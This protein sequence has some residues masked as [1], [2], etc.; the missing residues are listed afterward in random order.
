MRGGYNGW[1]RVP[2]EG[3]T[4]KK[5]SERRIMSEA[6][7]DSQG[8]KPRKSKLAIVSLVLPLVVAVFLLVTYVT[9]VRRYPPSPLPPDIPKCIFLSACLIIGCALGIASLVQIKKS[10]GKLTGSALALSGVVLSGLL[11]S[12]LVYNYWSAYRNQVLRGSSRCLANLHTLGVA[13]ET[14]AAENGNRYPPHDK[15][16]DLLLEPVPYLHRTAPLFVY[17]STGEWCC[18]YA[19]NPN[20]RTD[21]P[22][23]MVLLFETKRGWNQFGGREILTTENH[24]PKGCHVLFNDG[25]VRFVKTSQVGELKWKAEEKK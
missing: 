24:K 11:A 2:V 16:C 10:R 25:S 17:L 15:W 3:R 14:Y 19:M 1:L 7:N 4:I 22:P 20:C 23:D 9:R 5:F 8:Q 13:L 6:E 18:I 12:G 21:S